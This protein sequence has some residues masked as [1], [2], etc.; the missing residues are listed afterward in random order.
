MSRKL[1]VLDYGSGN[2]RS[3]ERALRRAGAEVDVTADADAALAADGLVVPGV[4]AFA[5]CMRGLDAIGGAEIVRKRI[6]AGG[7]VLGI[8][9]GFQVL[10]G[11]GDEHGVRTAGVGQWPGGVTKLD[12]P[13]LPHMG[14]NVVVPARHSVL[15]AGV[16]SE[17]FYFVHSYAPREAPGL[18]T[19]AEH[20]ER[21]VAAVEDELVSGTQFHPEK[22]GDAGAQLLQNWLGTLS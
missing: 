10:F 5:A 8:C 2:L 19:T 4:G 7:P 18:V 6:A 21:F 1:V 12:A 16:E 17:R 11:Y 9:V 3:A 15:F 20:G 14:W 22:S 13:V